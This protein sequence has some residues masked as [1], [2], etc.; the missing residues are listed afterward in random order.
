MSNDPTIIPPTTSDASSIPQLRISGEVSIDLIAKAARHRAVQQI[1]KDLELA[2]EAEGMASSEL[3]EIESAMNGGLLYD[4]NLV[5][6]WAAALISD[7][8]TV[9]VWPTTEV[10]AYF[11]VIV[12]VDS[13]RKRGL[14]FASNVRLHGSIRRVYAY[15]EARCSTEA[16]GPI[17]A[18]EIERYISAH[19]AAKAAKDALRVAQDRHA[20]RNEIAN[21]GYNELLAQMVENHMPE[22]AALMASSRKQIVG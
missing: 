10:G 19:K 2:K 7:G 17:L 22:V 4:S 18:G 13:E 12:D 8:W 9:E 6:S 14:A 21:E 16:V 15:T 11:S 1:E 3:N 5:P 20:R